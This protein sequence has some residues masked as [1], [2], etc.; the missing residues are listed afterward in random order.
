[1]KTLFSIAIISA[2]SLVAVGQKTSWDLENTFGLPVSESLSFLQ[3]DVNGIS[4]FSL[5]LNPLG[6]VQFGP[7]INAEFGVKDDLAINAHIRIPPL[8]IISYVIRYDDEEVD[9]M[10]GIALGG[11]INK[12]FGENYSKPYGGIIIGYEK[13]TSIYSVGGSWEWESYVNVLYF[14]ING[15]YRF[16]FKDGFFINTG[17]FLGAGSAN[18][19][20]E[21]TDPSNGPG[22]EGARL[23]PFGMLEV[24]FGLEF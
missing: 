19:T 20:W 9:K 2:L 17:A 3:E 10:S 14:M 23:I 7:S 13:T 24:A 4:K 22:G 21:Y 8:G 11:G 16:R 12:F 5:S 6:F 1:M 18:W 15:G